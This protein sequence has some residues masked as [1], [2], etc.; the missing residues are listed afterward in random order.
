[1]EPIK[2]NFLPEIIIVILIVIFA[3]GIQLRSS[4]TGKNGTATET[5]TPTPLSFQLVPVPADMLSLG[6]GFLTENAWLEMTVITFSKET[7]EP[8][9]YTNLRVHELRGINGPVTDFQSADLT[10]VVLEVPTQYLPDFQNVMA[11][12]EA[13]KAITFRILPEPATPVPTSTK[14]DATTTNT[15]PPAV[16]QAYIWLPLSSLT[17]ADAIQLGKSR[18]VII[19]TESG[20]GGSGTPEPFVS[21]EF[22]V[23]ALAFLDKN[24]IRTE[25]YDKLKSQSILISIGM[26][27]LSQYGIAAAGKNQIYL[28][29][30]GNCLITGVPLP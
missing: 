29:P 18:L 30:D 23:Q 4:T 10:T 26:E 7:P 8:H 11:E 12:V 6:T 15:P 20:Q 14:A 17:Q 19:S 5:V 25:T 27:Q 3:I 22:C 1:V 24:G 9:I 16:G 28:V 13:G 21:H 2:K